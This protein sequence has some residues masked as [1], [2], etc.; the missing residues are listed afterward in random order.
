MKFQFIET[1]VETILD[2]MSQKL[3][4]EI[5][6]AAPVPGRISVYVPNPVNAAE[7]V[8][9]LNALLASSGYTA[10]EI[11]RYNTDGTPRLAVR[12]WT[13]VDAK[14]GAIPVE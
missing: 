3:G 11:E 14:K 10:M 5:D 2:E 7:A 6:R 12:V 9:L 1:P 4:I 13:I 8:R